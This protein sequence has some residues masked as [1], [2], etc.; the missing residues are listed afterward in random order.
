MKDRELARKS[1]WQY[2]DWSRHVRNTVRFLMF[3]FSENSILD[4]VDHG[5]RVKDLAPVALFTNA[6]KS[7]FSSFHI[8]QFSIFSTIGCNCL[9]LSNQLNYTCSEVFTIL[10][11]RLE[12]MD[13]YPDLY[14]LRKLQRDNLQLC[15]QD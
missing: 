6:V 4:P 11:N 10:I 9:L 15:L 8:R 12:I 7:A 3:D 2:D 14:E 1:L 5:P 13:S